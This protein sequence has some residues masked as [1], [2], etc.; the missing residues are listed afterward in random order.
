MENQSML[1][2][3]GSTVVFDL[4]LPQGRLLCDQNVDSITLCYYMAPF[5]LMILATASALTEGTRP[6]R[7]LFKAESSFAEQFY[8]WIWLLV[9]GFLACSFNILKLYDHQTP[10]P[11]GHQCDRQ[12]EDARHHFDVDPLFRKPRATP[13][14]AGFAGDL[15]GHL[16]AFPKKAVSWRWISKKKLEENQPWRWISKKI[17]SENVDWDRLG[18]FCETVKL[19]ETG[20]LKDD[21]DVVVGF[22]WCRSP[23]WMML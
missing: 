8:L 23:S 13:P 4:C 6:F 3:V 9:S 15:L 17:T 14:V 10:F 12:C 18:F 22:E 19:T 5:N 21:L 11:R 7:T 1:K 16:A 20:D 2:N